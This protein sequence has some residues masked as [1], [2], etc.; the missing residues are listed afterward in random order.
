[1]KSIISFFSAAMMLFSWTA[2]SGLLEVN[3][4]KAPAAIGPYSQAVQAGEYLFISGQLPIDPA[5]GKFVEGEITKQTAQV[6]N[7]IEA[8]LEAKGLS[9]QDVVKTEVY[10]QEMSDFKSMN[11]VYADRFSH[12]IKPA[13]QAMQ[14]AKLPLNALVEISCIAFIS[15]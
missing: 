13:R 7:N 4:T 12:A 9:L 1:M 2:Y 3:T 6:I 14:V 15:N 10:L 5:T 11:A 8:I